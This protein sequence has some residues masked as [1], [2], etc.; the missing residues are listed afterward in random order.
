MENKMKTPQNV[1]L[2][3]L[4]TLSTLGAC[5]SETHCADEADCEVTEETSDETEETSETYLKR[6]LASDLITGVKHL[7][8]ASGP[9]HVG[10]PTL[11]GPPGKEVEVNSS[12]RDQGANSASMTAEYADPALTDSIWDLLYDVDLRDSD[13]SDQDSEPKNAVMRQVVEMANG[14]EC[15]VRGAVVGAFFDGIFGGSAIQGGVLNDIEIEGTFV[16]LG[17]AGGGIFE[18]AY[19]DIED[20]EGT[21]MGTLSEPRLY[22][23][24]PFTTFEAS[25]GERTAVVSILEGRLSGVWLGAD[26]PEDGTFLGYWTVCNDEDEEATQEHDPQ[27]DVPNKRPDTIEKP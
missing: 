23:S 2:I 11:V 18:G 21:L 4:M 10:D 6:G 3:A 9:G 13:G 8:R 12:D 24:G 22:E 16:D 14:E 1:H 19:N 27:F 25:W 15:E 20:S 26:N 17:G 7:E 5:A